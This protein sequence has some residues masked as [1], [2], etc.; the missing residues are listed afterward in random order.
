MKIKYLCL[1]DMHF[2]QL[3]S[4]LTNYYLSENEMVEINLKEPNEVLTTFCD[5]LKRLIFAANH[6]EGVNALTL[7]EEQKVTL[8]LNGDN[9]ELALN[10]MNHSSLAFELFIKRMV[11]ELFNKIVFIPGNHDHH[12]WE[13]AREYY[14]VEN[15]SNKTQASLPKPL[16]HT[17]MFEKPDR[18]LLSC[19]K[20]YEADLFKNFIIDNIVYRHCTSDECTI[21]VAYPNYALKNKDK[22]VVFHHGHFLNSF[23]RFVSK[24]KAWVFDTADPVNTVYE[25]E[26]DNFAWLDFAW[27]SFARSGYSDFNYLFGLYEGLKYKTLKKTIINRLSNGI[28]ELIHTPLPEFV[29]RNFIKTAINVV[30]NG[31]FKEKEEGL[32]LS[33]DQVEGLIQYLD[34]QIVNTL[35]AELNDDFNEVKNIVFAF[36]HTHKPYEAIKTLAEYNKYLDKKEQTS[37]NNP[38][39]FYNT[40]GWLLETKKVNPY[41]GASILLLDENLNEASLHLFK[42]ATNNDNI[43][44]VEIK[45]AYNADRKEN[46]FYWYLKSIIDKPEHQYFFENFMR[47]VPKEVEKRYIIIEKSLKAIY[48]MNFKELKPA[49]FS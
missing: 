43:I 32:L 3:N 24:I 30:S 1:S 48:R 26:N 19:D 33:I 35:K 15:I 36:G 17:F 5:G 39:T 42:I 6:P 23:I 12:I 38:I 25:L 9:I 20:A 28:S 22:V 37:Y 46:T 21:K 40:G 2:G 34:R 7:D 31:L 11:P 41:L 8:I 44:P 18:S 14:F 45:T 49:D 10:T 27:S 47:A 4:L 16:H 13:I 29:E